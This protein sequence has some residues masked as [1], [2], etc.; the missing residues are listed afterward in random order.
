MG[1][2]NDEY[3]PGFYF[4]SSENDANKYKQG[5]DPSFHDPKME[6]IKE[7]KTPGIIKARVNLKNP[8]SIGPGGVGNSI[9][10]FE[11]NRQQATQMVKEAVKLQGQVLL[12]DWGE[13]AYDGR[14]MIIK[15]MIDVYANSSAFIALYDLFSS[16]LEKGLRLLSKITGYDGVV[17]SFEN[18]TVQTVAWFPEQIEIVK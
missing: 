13:V 4:T 12:E 14:A 1:K 7:T 17:V 9:R 18:G 3:G 6:K 16:E 8:L 5:Y 10:S 2:R 11:I 15:R